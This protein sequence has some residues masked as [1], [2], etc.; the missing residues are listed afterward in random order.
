ML[1]FSHFSIF[2][3]AGFAD[4]QK[5]GFL[6]KRKE[7]KTCKS[8]PTSPLRGIKELEKVK[9]KTKKKPACYITMKI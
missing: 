2:A 9:T 8:F 7:K 4:K 1:S 5:M 6:P 3:W